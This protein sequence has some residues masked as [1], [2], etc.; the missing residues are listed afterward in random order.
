V[1]TTD[2]ELRIDSYDPLPSPAAARRRRAQSV[3]LSY[4]TFMQLGA[5]ERLE[6]FQHLT[7]ANQ[8]ALAREQVVRWRRLHAERLTPE[9]DQILAE[10]VEYIGPEQ[11]GSSR[12]HSDDEIQAF[13]SLAERISGAFT[14]EESYNVFTLR[15]MYLPPQ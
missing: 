15:G 8:A 12:R 14:Q 11:F 4:D 3:T 9:Q 2:E 5:N 1:T 10:V 6:R 13:K 7:P